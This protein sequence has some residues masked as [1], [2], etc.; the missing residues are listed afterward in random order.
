MQNDMNDMKKHRA[1]MAKIL[2]SA[3]SLK[4]ANVVQEEESAHLILKLLESPENLFEHIKIEAGAVI[5]KLTY[6][7][8]VNQHGKDHLVDIAGQM[9]ED[10]S[11][12]F[13]PGRWMVDILPF[14]ESC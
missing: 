8:N 7:Y 12:A 5:L 4:V 11:E 9:M 3:K 14:R 1:N 2:G 6:G 13:I 10:F